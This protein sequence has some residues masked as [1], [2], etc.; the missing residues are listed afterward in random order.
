MPEGNPGGYTGG[1][2]D[3]RPGL[4][5]QASGGQMG[6][7]RRSLGSSLI[8]SGL[9]T[10]GGG[11]AKALD[12]PAAGY[13]LAKVGADIADTLRDEWAKQEAENFRSLYGQAYQQELNAIMEG[14]S[15]SMT[16]VP[17]PMAT[18]ETRQVG[19]SE[20]PPP[21]KPAAGKEGK[22]AP[23]QPKSPDQLAAAEREVKT[24]STPQRPRM[25]FV[26]PMT[27]VFIPADDMQAS[28][29]YVQRQTQS[30]FGRLQS[31]TNEFLDAAGQYADN[32]YIANQTQQVVQTMAQVVQGEAEARAQATEFA[33]RQRESEVMDMRRQE[34]DLRVQEHSLRVQEAEREQLEQERADRL[35]VG[36]ARGIIG[37]AADNMS[38]EQLYDAA[39]KIQFEDQLASKQGR[40]PSY[41]N[42]ENMT[43]YL[44]TSEAGQALVQRGT[45]FAMDKLAPQILAQAKALA[46]AE[47]QDWSVLG[48]E[49][50]GAYASEAQAY[51]RS[52]IDFYAMEQAA[53]DAFSSRPGVSRSEAVKKAREMVRLEYPNLYR[54]IYPEKRAEPNKTPLEAKR[55]QLKPIMEEADKSFKGSKVKKFMKWSDALMSDATNRSAEIT[56]AAILRGEDLVRSVTDEKAKKEI[57][58]RLALLYH[59]KASGKSRTEN[60]EDFDEAFQT[61]MQAGTGGFD[62]DPFIYQEV[63]EQ[64]QKLLELYHGDKAFTDMVKKR[65]RIME[66]AGKGGSPARFYDPEQGQAFGRGLLRG[67][68]P[69]G[70]MG[71]LERQESLPYPAASEEEQTNRRQSLRD[72]ILR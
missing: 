31:A 44:A 19:S 37:P 51:L 7:I 3:P 24:T 13:G 65:I 12:N 58:D 59:M 49:E 11:L 54:Q 21:Q 43:H 52:T 34:H 14:Y 35:M 30:Y 5:K 67:M 66:Q 72:R 20:T 50:K 42:V 64:G 62:E 9:A 32:P 71:L 2:L 4:M 29:Q 39:A 36:Y 38:E 60:F 22:P 16:M 41:V 55:N 61:A 70:T 23:K 17:D 27:G 25:G 68:A 33:D 46:K 53:K 1:P 45:K 28:T 57:R 69:P 48:E 40:I 15:Q 10:M 8:E 26:D 18:E 56:D 63:I 6:S 47:G